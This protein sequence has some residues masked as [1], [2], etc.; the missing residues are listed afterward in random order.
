MQPSSLQLMAASAKTE[1]AKAAWMVADRGD[2]DEAVA[3]HSG[4]DDVAYNGA[5]E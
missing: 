1:M 5:D 3:M 2:N 4:A